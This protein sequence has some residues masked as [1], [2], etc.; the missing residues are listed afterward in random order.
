MFYVSACLLNTVIAHGIEMYIQV[1]LFC[2]KR[3]LIYT[4]K[5]IVFHLTYVFVLADKNIAYGGRPIYPM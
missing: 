3:N 5:Y 4:A 2:H 1:L